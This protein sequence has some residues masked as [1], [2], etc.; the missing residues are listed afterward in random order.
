MEEIRAGLEGERIVVSQEGR[1]L[2][3]CE[4]RVLPPIFKHKGQP[5]FPDLS[6]DVYLKPGYQDSDIKI[7]RRLELKDLTENEIVDRIVQD[8]EHSSN[9]NSRFR[10]EYKEPAWH[11]SFAKLAK[12]LMRKSAAWERVETLKIIPLI[13]GEWVTPLSLHG[14]PV[15]LPYIIDDGTVQIQIPGNLGLQ[16]IDPMACVDSEAFAFYAD[17]G[18]S[19]C[20]EQIVIGKI[21]EVHKD[22]YG[23]G[24]IGDYIEHLEILF[25]FCA[26]HPGFETFQLRAVDPNGTLR[27]TKDFFFQSEK[28]Y[29]AEKLLRETYPDNFEDFEFEDFGFLHSA[30]M[31]SSVQHSLRG[32]MTW[33]EFLERL[34]VRYY[35]SL[36]WS[37]ENPATLHPALALVARDNPGL[38]VP[39]LQAHWFECYVGQSKGLGE[40]IKRTSVLCQRT[41]VLPQSSWLVPLERT[42]LPSRELLDKSDE[43]SLR[44][45]L[46]FLELADGALDERIDN[47]MFLRQFGV[48]CQP[49]LDFYLLSLNKLIELHSAVDGS[50][51]DETKSRCISAYLGIVNVATLSDR[52][53]LKV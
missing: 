22:S 15:Y 12:D 52:S 2:P 3:P 21:L 32:Q 18:I 23:N 50:S 13:G 36:Y 25:W 42:L 35:P 44:S 30:Y 19:S 41:S 53:I 10:G 20:S 14:N 7:L 38:F 8:I 4:A 37:I 33:E 40:V 17:V 5:L 9:S 29:N 31:Q 47:W 27:S 11:S 51:S 45:V 49:D 26:S 28:A 43:L 39:N 46:P 1:L 6:N 34:G 16:R 48:I 24:S